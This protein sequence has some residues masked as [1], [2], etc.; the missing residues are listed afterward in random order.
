MQT[1]TDA[2]GE[3][4]TRRVSAPGLGG[5]ESFNDLGS[6]PDISGFR[7]RE[8]LNQ[9]Q[10]ERSQAELGTIVTRNDIQTDLG[11]FK[12]L[13]NYKTAYPKVVVE[14][15]CELYAEYNRAFAPLV[16]ANREHPT[17]YQYCFSKDG[18]PT[19]YF[20][21]VDMIGLPEKF[22]EVAKGMSKDDLKQVL[23]ERVFEIENSLAC[24]QLLERIFETDSSSP[25]VFKEKFRNALDQLRH[26]HSKPI[27][28]LAV[29][30]QK[31][32]AMRASEFGK[33][34]GDTLSDDEVKALSGFDK[35][36][37]PEEFK[38][39]LN[40]NHGKCDYLLYVRSSDPVDK[41]KHPDVQ[42]DN[43]LLADPN[44]RR[45]IKENTITFNID[46]PEMSAERRINDT[47]EY[48]LSMG[49][50]FLVKAESD[51]YSPELAKHLGQH[52]RY[53]EFKGENRLSDRFAA[54]LASQDIEVTDV[55]D[56]SVEL[57]AK[58]L[59]GTYGC[60]GHVH[61]PLPDRDFRTELRT[62]L[63]KRGEYLVQM[64]M[65]PAT[66]LNE[67]DGHQ[68]S[69]IDRNFLSF[70]NGKAEFIC[71][72]RSLMRSDATEAQKGR[73]HG[74]KDT[75]WAEIVVENDPNAN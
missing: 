62:E 9:A 35:F 2:S 69:Y 60:Y 46:A 50:G 63:R 52:K 32:D 30:E 26:T 49:M 8:A 10:R 6:L 5:L 45:T 43:P 59:K 1:N 70:T 4:P 67:S 56:G 39:Y 25:T 19:N 47:K 34:G 12:T 28:L 20:I 53:V 54:F 40:Q 58:P 41:L 15:L 55:E 64:E 27:A 11:P 18:M 37:G 42:V 44:L 57:R 7:P 21:Q 71:G 14:A 75:V 31:Y 73:L 61:G 3:E 72:F 23:R 29:T 16:E 51:L 33:F 36:F 17:D 24:Y 38:E 65:K 74:S 48:M 68:Y 66:I 22:L 13:P